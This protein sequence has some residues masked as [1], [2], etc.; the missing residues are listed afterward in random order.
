MQNHNMNVSAGTEKIKVF[1]SGGFLD[2]NGLTAN[3]NFKKTDLRFN[4]DV[5]LT[6]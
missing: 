6:R 4:T 5:A 1:A 2:Q 3:T